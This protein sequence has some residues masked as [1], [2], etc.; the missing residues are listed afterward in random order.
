ML[1]IHYHKKFRRDYKK[2]PAKI[3]GLFKERLAIFREQPFHP[4]LKNHTLRRELKDYWAFSV[5]GDIRVIYEYLDKNTI[6]L[7]R[8]GSH[9]QVY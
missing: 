1:K 3:R 8:I 7:V 4:L 6:A 2:M 9:N 5:T